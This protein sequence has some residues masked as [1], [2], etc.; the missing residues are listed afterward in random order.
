MVGQGL[1]EY[2][3]VFTVWFVCYRATAGHADPVGD[4]LGH[5]FVFT[6]DTEQLIFKAA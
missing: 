5:Q 6:V 1:F 3:L 4:A 2:D